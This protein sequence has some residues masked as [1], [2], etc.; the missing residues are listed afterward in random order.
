MVRRRIIYAAVAKVVVCVLKD[1]KR[2]IHDKAAQDE[3]RDQRPGPPRIAALCLGETML[4]KR[5]GVGGHSLK[6]LQPNVNSALYIVPPRASIRAQWP[7]F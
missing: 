1:P 6:I 4:S 5:R 2:R 3:R 7:S